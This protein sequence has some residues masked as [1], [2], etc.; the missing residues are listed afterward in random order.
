MEKTMMLD[1]LFDKWMAMHK[2][3]VF[4]KDGIVDEKAYSEAEIKVLFI[5][6]DMHLKYDIEKYKELGYVDMRMLVPS[7][8]GMWNA[9]ESW[10]EAFFD[11]KEEALTKIAFLNLKKEYGKETVS[12]CCIMH[13]SK[14]DKELIKEEIEIISPDVIIACSHIV[15]ECLKDIF[16]TPEECTE[17]FVF[18][19]KMQGYGE[20]FDIGAL[21]SEKAVR[22]VHYRHPAMSGAKEVH[23]ENMRKIRKSIQEQ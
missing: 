13:C 12:D 8:G 4:C 20:C 17:K 6:K 14:R 10:A 1:K 15:Y 7:E 23:Q 19:D 5:L 16:D 2:F 3:D 22:V 11:S 9:V 18:N 21:N